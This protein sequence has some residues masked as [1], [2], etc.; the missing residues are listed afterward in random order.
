MEKT[1]H[2]LWLI[3]VW[4][5]LCPL[6]INAQDRTAFGEDDW[7]VEPRESA[8]SEGF[9]VE[10]FKDDPSYAYYE[11]IYEESLW[12]RVQRW[13]GILWAKFWDW[14]LGGDEATG[15]IAFVIQV[16]PWLAATGILAVLVWVL[17]NLERDASD[18]GFLQV[19]QVRI[20]ADEDIIQD[21][22]IDQLIGR[23]TIAEDY[24][25]AIRYYYLQAL[26]LLTQKGLIKWQDQKTNADYIREIPQGN[27]KDKFTHVTLA[28]DAI[29]YGNF[30][31]DRFLFSRTVQSF[32]QLKALI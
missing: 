5:V 28:Y 2:N 4:F 19:N 11:G 32:E 16:L 14:I 9:T 29:W 1:K 3:L 24:P 15:I 20:L 6:G 18:K 21:A 25:L 30:E 8:D 12:D 13:P 31:V 10:S 22:A 27:V 17:T 7:D 23:A 26:Q